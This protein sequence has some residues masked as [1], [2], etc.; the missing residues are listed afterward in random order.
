MTTA[1]T[2]PAALFTEGA[3]EADGFTIRY[4]EAGEGDPLVVLH[5]AGGLQFS[6]ALDLLA[7]RL[8]V[9]L[10]EMPGFGDQP[11]DRHNSLAELAATIH[12][13]TRALGLDRFHLLGHSF[14]G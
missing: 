11:N 5:G 14:G 2:A 13:A 1:P 12:L 8:R 10:L 3:V 6:P 4:F 9:I 7:G